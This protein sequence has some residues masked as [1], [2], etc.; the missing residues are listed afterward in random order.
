M[1]RPVLLTVIHL[2]SEIR[3]AYY[4]F[5]RDDIRLGAW[6]YPNGRQVLRMEQI[7]PETEK[8]LR[9]DRLDCIHTAVQDISV[10]ELLENEAD[11]EFYNE[12]FTSLEAVKVSAL[13]I[14]NPR[15][16]LKLFARGWREI[17]EDW[18]RCF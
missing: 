18:G 6:V 10:D 9:S 3:K 16:N 1:Y 12:M 15:R 14:W 5:I 7:D 11:P 4:P 2:E 17:A 8:I 13:S